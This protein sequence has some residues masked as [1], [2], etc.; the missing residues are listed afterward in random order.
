MPTF[1]MDIKFVRNVIFGQFAFDHGENP[2]MGCECFY[3]DNYWSKVGGPHC[4]YIPK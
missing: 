3:C 2:Q 4:S 1:E